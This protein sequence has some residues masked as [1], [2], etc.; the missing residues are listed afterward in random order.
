MKITAAVLAGM[1]NAS[2]ALAQSTLKGS[3]NYRACYISNEQADHASQYND[4][5]FLAAIINE[6]S[7][8]GMGGIAGPRFVEIALD[9]RSSFA[10]VGS[11]YLKEQKKED[12]AYCYMAKWRPLDKKAWSS[13]RA[14][15]TDYLSPAMKKRFFSVPER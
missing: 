4:G 2:P 12:L 15:L 14:G 10:N 5:K 13:V 8:K 9:T 11:L 3:D 1:L 6:V 7:V